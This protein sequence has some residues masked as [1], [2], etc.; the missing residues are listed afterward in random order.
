MAPEDDETFATWLRCFTSWLDSL[1]ARSRRRETRRAYQGDVLDF[2]AT[3]AAENVQFWQVSRQHAIAW[4]AAMRAR[5]LAPATINRRLAAM[6]SLYRYA[7]DE[8][9]VG[10]GPAERPLWPHAN[11][12]G[13]KS[14]RSKVTPYGRASYLGMEEVHA[15]LC[16]IDT[17]TATGWR[18][19]ALLYGMFATTRRVSEWIGLRWGDVHEGAEGRH[20]FTYRGK[21]G[22]VERQLMPPTAWELIRGWLERAGRW[23]PEPSDYLFTATADAARRFRQSGAGVDPNQQPITA[24]YANRLLKRYGIPAGIAPDRLH[25]HAL[26]HAGARARNEMGASVLQISKILGHASIAITQVYVEELL[27]EPIDEFAGRVGEVLPPGIPLSRRASRSHA[28][29]G[30]KI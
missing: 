13:A 9:H 8:F 18:N 25:C 28:I 24:S 19:L 29:I 4:V 2:F 15:L 10:A 23:P 5:G 30:R 16:T 7:A 22:K 17:T 1:E 27:G 20:W 3:F 6:T 12:C 11:P 14:L 21:G 26:R